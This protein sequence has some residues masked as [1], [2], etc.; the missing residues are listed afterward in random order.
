MSPRGYKGQ[1]YAEIFA[2]QKMAISCLLG[3]SKKCRILP[4]VSAINPV[5]SVSQ[6][7]DNQIVLI[8]QFKEL[9]I[10]IDLTRGPTPMLAQNISSHRSP[11]ITSRKRNQWL[12][13][14]ARNKW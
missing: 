8:E 12:D 11:A 9:M 1:F 6:Y 2:L 7:P 13:Q 4:I 5:V 3:P 14:L 10:R